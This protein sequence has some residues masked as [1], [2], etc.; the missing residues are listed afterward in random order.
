MDDKVNIG[1]YPVIAKGR[2]IEF[3]VHARFI[4][5]TRMVEPCIGPPAIFDSAHIGPS[6]GTMMAHFVT[7]E[8]AEQW[9]NGFNHRR[10]VLHQEV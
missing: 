5:N 2:G 10:A 9:I 3:A 4:G 1:V 6:L 8:A 7:F